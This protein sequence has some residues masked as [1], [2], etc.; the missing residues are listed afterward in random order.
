MMPPL[1]LIVMFFDDRRHNDFGYFSSKRGEVSRGG[2]FLPSPSKNGMR[3]SISQ[4][5]CDKLIAATHHDRD[6]GCRPLPP[7]SPALYNN[8]AT[9]RNCYRLQSSISLSLGLYTQHTYHRLRFKTCFKVPI[10]P[11]GSKT[12]LLFLLPVHQH[13]TMASFGGFGQAT[14]EAGSTPVEPST[15]WVAASDGNLAL[16][17]KSLSALQLQPNAADP[18]GYTLAHAAAAYNQIHILKWLL[19]Q[20]GGCKV[21]AQDS[22]G[23][24]PLHHVE[25]LEAAQFLL[26]QMAANP[27]V[28][29]G[30][31]KTAMNVKMEE[32][33]EQMVDPDEDVDEEL[34]ALVEYLQHMT[35]L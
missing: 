31:N 26:E 11:F 34:K 30:D 29:N 27:S 35:P 14:A 10:I 6:G 33:M 17:Q 12:T 4:P 2:S 3:N 28:K 1:M 15:P 18:N 9:K 5:S 22:D 32:M 7:S 23:D 20:P 8:K 16:V 19:S 24:T 21:N 25:H 13:T